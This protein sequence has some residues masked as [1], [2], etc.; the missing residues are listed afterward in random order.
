MNQKS[1]FLAHFFGPNGLTLGCHNFLVQ[2]GGP[3]IRQK[4]FSSIH[5]KWLTVLACPL[6][7]AL[8]HSFFKMPKMYKSSNLV[9]LVTNIHR[10]DYVL[11]VSADIKK[12]IRSNS[13]LNT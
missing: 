9:R 5:P 4:N 7:L 1:L 11:S 8:G 12:A 13:K 10:K 6:G 3:T 2:V